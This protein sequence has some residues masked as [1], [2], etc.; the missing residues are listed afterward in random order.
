[1]SRRW[2]QHE[3]NVIRHEAVRDDLNRL[4][5]RLLAKQAQVALPVARAEKHRFAV[6]ATLGDVVWDAW[7]D[8]SC[9]PR[10]AATLID[11]RPP[12]LADY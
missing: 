6:I 8:D 5:R 2:D 9:V 10:H 11:R 3:M 7:E 12:E 4:C 1:M